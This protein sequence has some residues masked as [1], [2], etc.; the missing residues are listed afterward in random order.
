ML[1]ACGTMV[2]MAARAAVVVVVVVAVAAV[3]LACR[4]VRACSTVARRG[5]SVVH[6]AVLPLLTSPWELSPSGLAPK[7][8]HRL[9]GISLGPLCCLNNFQYVKQGPEARACG[10]NMK[11]RGASRRRHQS[12]R[13]LCSAQ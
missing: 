13:S 11:M 9:G 2:G 8:S 3:V 5:V 10:L 12:R 4:C 6:V 7:N 1:W